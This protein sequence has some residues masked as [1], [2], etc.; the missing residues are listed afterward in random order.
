MTT[1]EVV[2]EVRRIISK[3]DGSEGDLLEAL[4]TESEGW[5]MRLEELEEEE[6]EDEEEG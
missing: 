1:K 2:N 4:M 3:H 6:Y 5:K